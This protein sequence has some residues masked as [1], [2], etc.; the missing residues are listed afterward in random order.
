MAGGFT[1][2]GSRI[3]SVPKL[4]VVGGT[5][6]FVNGYKYH[7]FGSSGTFNVTNL[8]ISGTT[9][10]VLIVAG[11]GGGGSWSTGASGGGGAGGILEINN[12]NLTTQAYTITVGG[13]GAQNASGGNSVAFS[14]TAVG[15]GYGTAQG[16]S[17]VGGNGGSGGAPGSYAS[18]STNTNTPGKGVYP[19]STF[20]DQ[21]RQ[22]Y[23]SSVGFSYNW[24]GSGAGGGANST[25]V[26]GGLGGS[27]G[28]QGGN[29]YYSAN[30]A[31]FG[32]DTNL[33]YF[34]SG[35]SAY[36]DGGYGNIS[37]QRVPGGGGFCGNT[38]GKINTGGGGGGP[39]DGQGSTGG[40]GVVIIRY[41]A[42]G[43]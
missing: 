14:Y 26:Q 30:F 34:S 6:S 4:V 36:W 22:G 13:A 27:L 41:A 40:S 20:L 8:P 23:D 1:G 33:G 29:G 43:L 35:G 31:Q 10:S 17:A 9:V 42:T 39:I 2:Y 37:G 24:G 19:G 5:T 28:A 16:P 38:T 18:Y 32:D 11:G 12:I 21:P 3:T 25:A 7:F 15:G